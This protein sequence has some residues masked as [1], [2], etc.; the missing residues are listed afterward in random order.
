MPRSMK[1]WK[2]KTPN[3]QRNTARGKN[4]RISQ[5]R[6]FEFP[7]QSMK[8]ATVFMKS[9]R[10]IQRTRNN[11]QLIDHVN[12]NLQRRRLRCCHSLTSLALN[13]QAGR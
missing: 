5:T 7:A 11:S 8:Y 10:S 9:H 13:V 2:G 4:R 12:G 1:E 6:T 3:P